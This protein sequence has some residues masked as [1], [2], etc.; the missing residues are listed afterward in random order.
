MIMDTDETEGKDMKNAL[1]LS[2]SEEEEEIEDLA[3]HFARKT[4]F[5]GVEVRFARDRPNADV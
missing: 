5:L 4:A 3:E 2:E 1:D